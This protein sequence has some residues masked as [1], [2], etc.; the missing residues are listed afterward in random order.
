MSNRNVLLTVSACAISA[1]LAL[2]GCSTASVP[3][4]GSINP[5]GGNSI[6][7]IDRAYLQAA[8][9]WDLNHDSV[10]TCNEWKSYA[11]DLFNS[12]D[13]NHDDFV[14][15]SEWQ[16]LTNID[17]MF[18]TADLKYFD[19]NGDGKVSRQEFVD[20]PNPAFVLMDKGGTC[21]LD[22]N[23]IASARSKTEY[24]VSG[25]KA[26]NSDPRDGEGAQGQAANG[27]IGR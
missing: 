21:K 5:F 17:K 23:Q 4:I 14:D 20:K 10:V 9:S 22:A 6:S 16:N 26:G 19:A 13:T 2:G 8:G 11:E 1:A 27:A 25:G 7:E 18:V 3:T 24:D 12:A 15:A